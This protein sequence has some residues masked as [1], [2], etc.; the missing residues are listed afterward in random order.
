MRKRSLITGSFFLT[1]TGGAHRLRQGKEGRGN[2]QYILDSGQMKQC[3]A[4]TMERYGMLSAVLMERAAL[5]AAEEALR[6]LP[7]KRKRFLI[8]CGTGNNGGDGLAIARLLFLKGQE[9]TILFPGKEEKCSVEAARQL[10]I[11]RRYGIP[12]VT[13]MPEGDFDVV[14]DAIFGIGLD[15]EVGGVYRDL[16]LQMNRMPAWKM[17][18]DISSG[19]SADDGAVLAAPSGQT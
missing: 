15:R 5:T 13:Q 6:Y 4:N 14:M 7:E 1:E 17:A 10:E 2:M 19:I 9:V 18:V 11:V 16:I 8:V 12:L 3:D